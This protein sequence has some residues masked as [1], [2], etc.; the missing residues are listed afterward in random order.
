[1]S[2]AGV[3]DV[4]A[5]SPTIPTSFVTDSGTAVPAL[6]V[7]NVHGGAGITT[8]GAGNTITIT[9]V[10]SGFT[11]N[12][13]TS[14]SN[15]VTLVKENGYIPKGAGAVNFVLPAA[16]AVGDEFQIVGYG[17]LWSIA[18]N[19]GQTITLGAKTTTAGV[20]GSM[21]ATMVT[22]G[23]QLVCVTANTEFFVVE[24]IGNPAII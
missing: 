23:I 1:L 3:L 8:T 6:N 24:S 14:A 2:Q 22:D 9:V 5:S 11:W 7:L 20:G 21:T 4:I 15:P 17:N 10:S 12:V 16:A 19:A 18:Q 13:V